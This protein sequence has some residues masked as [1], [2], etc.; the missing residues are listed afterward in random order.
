MKTADVRG[1]TAQYDNSATK[2]SQLNG[3]VAGMI[4]RRLI[5]LFIRPLM[6]FIND[7]KTEVGQRGKQ[8]APW[9]DDN[10]AVPFC[11]PLPFVELLSQGKTTVQHCH[12]A[13]EAISE[14]FYCL[15]GQGDFR[16]KTD[17]FLAG[18]DNPG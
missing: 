16:D 6:F 13:G 10:M 3:Y 2:V 17:A 9:S 8:S 18:G 11:Y 4:A 15:L 5:F 12:T 1:G 14:S 7:D